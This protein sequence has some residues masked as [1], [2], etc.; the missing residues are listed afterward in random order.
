LS[1]AKNGT[2]PLFDPAVFVQSPSRHQHTQTLVEYCVKPLRILHI[3][4]LHERAPFEGMSE[5]R[6]AK[7]QLDKEQRG[8]VLG[9]SFS[10]ALGEIAENGVDLVCFTGDVVDWGHPR[11]YLAATFRIEQI[12]KL[13]GVGKDR[14]FA[15]PGNHDVQRHTAQDAWMGIRGWYSDTHNGSALGRW[16]REA[17]KPPPGTSP[18][19]RNGVLKRTEEFWNW[20]DSFGQTDLRPHPPKLLGFRKTLAVGTFEHIDSEVHIIGLDSAWLCGADDDQ[21]H[22]LVTEEQVS[23]HV[24][25]G[26]M[27][28]AGFRIALIHH[29]L[30]HLADHHEVRRLLAD[31]GVD[32]LLHGHQHNAM[33]MTTDE[34]GAR[35]RVLAAGCLIEGDLGKNWPNEFQ[36]IE[37][38]VKRK[39]VVVHFRKWAQNARYWAKG[40]DI[41]RHAPDGILRLPYESEAHLATIGLEE[42]TDPERFA[43]ETSPIESAI[44]SG[45]RLHLDNTL[46]H[47]VVRCLEGRATEVDVAGLL[48]LANFLVFADTVVFGHLE[49]DSVRRTSE[50]L[51]RELR[52]RKLEDSALKHVTVSPDNFEN[53]CRLAAAKIA[54]QVDALLQGFPLDFPYERISLQPEGVEVHVDRYQRVHDLIQRRTQS[55]DE[56]ADI[57]ERAIAARRSVGAFEYAVAVDNALR[58]A[59]QKAFMNLPWTVS[60]TERMALLFKIH[61]NH[62][63]AARQ[64]ALH[65]PAPAR[66][67]LLRDLI[68]TTPKAPPNNLR[69]HLDLLVPDVARFLARRSGGNPSR[70]LAEAIDLRAQAAPIRLSLR[71]LARELINGQDSETKSEFREAA[72]RLVGGRTESHASEDSGLKLHLLVK[73]GSVRLELELKTNLWKRGPIVAVSH[74]SAFFNPGDPDFKML[75]RNSCAYKI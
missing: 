73:L 19:W 52:A 70:V 74:D 8:Y 22:I 16:F 48:G 12:L 34:P 71:S 31:D 40:S 23:A 69:T 29:P 56:L 72:Q 18:E 54:P 64:Q 42:S 53:A 26:E 35:L 13:V 39:S 9:Q 36:L 3:S 38:D 44:H 65:A 43:A 45:F 15:V 28:L 55:A 7:L 58:E 49:L 27:P 17:L 11:E 14:F 21:G 75:I 50:R 61:L 46:I 30:D 4:D 25:D 10:I 47:G 67:R 57:A 62:V 33:V 6:N 2:E 66:M 24:R 63:L 37:V 60:M 41:Y 51:I 68:S 20:L 32:L 1:G 59:L 5:S